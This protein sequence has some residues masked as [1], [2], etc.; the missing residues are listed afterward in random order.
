MNTTAALI[1][2]QSEGGFA[3]LGYEVC[4]GMMSKDILALAWRYYLSYTGLAGYYTVKPGLNAMD[5]Y[6][7]ALGEAMLPTVQ[8]RIEQTTGLKLLPTYSFARIYTTESRLHKHVDR[9]ACE[10]SATMTVGYRN[11]AELWPI[12]VESEGVAVPL[13]LDVG[14]ALIYRGMTLPHWREPLPSGLWCQLFFHFV[15]AGGE[16]VGLALDGRGRLGPH[17]GG[18]TEVP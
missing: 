15:E 10:V 1:G 14:D 4:P 16:M 6:A 5:R 2:E 11:V 3:L 17:A 13:A 9:G 7:D 12:L 8:T 18:M